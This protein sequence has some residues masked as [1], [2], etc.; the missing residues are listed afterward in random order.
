M[1]YL[2]SGFFQ[3]TRQVAKLIS[4]NEAHCSYSPGSFVDINADWNLSYD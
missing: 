4:I 2:E 1:N 3:K